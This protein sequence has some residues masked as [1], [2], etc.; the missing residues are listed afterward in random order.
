[1]LRGIW[2]ERTGQAA[3]RY[4]GLARVVVSSIEEK[5]QER[6]EGGGIFI[7]EGNI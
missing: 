4:G 7:R 2:R 5:T 1:V 3:N 6:S